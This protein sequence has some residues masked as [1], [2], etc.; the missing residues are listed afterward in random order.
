MKHLICP[1]CGNKETE[2][3]LFPGI[4]ASGTAFGTTDHEMTG[5]YGCPKCKTV[6]YCTDSD[7]IQYRKLIY[8][9]KITELKSE[10]E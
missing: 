2:G 7:Y 6:Q 10:S 3:N 1:N 8:K 4:F 9:R 5:L